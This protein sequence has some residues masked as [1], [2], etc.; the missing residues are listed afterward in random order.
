MTSIDKILIR[1]FQGA[2]S[3][4]T[5]V[6]T[7][8]SISPSE[9]SHMTAVPYVAAA[10]GANAGEATTVSPRPTTDH[11]MPDQPIT[12]QPITDQSTC[13]T[14]DRDCDSAVSH[15]NASDIAT[16]ESTASALVAYEGPETDL[17]I[18]DAE[19]V[20]RNAVD[21]PRELYVEPTQSTQQ[22][23]VATLRDEQPAVESA[24]STESTINDGG[25]VPSTGTACTIIIDAY[26]PNV[27]PAERVDPIDCLD[28]IPATELSGVVEAMDRPQSAYQLWL[29][30]R[31]A[32]A[33]PEPESLKVT[34]HP[35]EL[36][37]AGESTDTVTRDDGVPTQPVE[38]NSEL[39]HPPAAPNLIND[40]PSRRDFSPAWEVDGLSWSTVVA[41][42][43]DATEQQIGEFVNWV[44][45][46]KP[47]HETPCLSVTS[48]QRGEGRTTLACLIA[49]QA[50]SRG[51]RVALVDN[52]HQSPQ[53]AA[54]MGLLP[55][56][57]WNELTAGEA[58]DQAAIHSL[59]DQL[60]LF[61]LR[62]DSQQDADLSRVVAELR[63]HFDLIVIDGPPIDALR[64]TSFATHEA[65]VYLIVRNAE[66]TS[67]LDL[68]RGQIQLQG[69]G[70]GCLGIAKNFAA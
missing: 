3:I 70:V 35:N 66:V 2:Q 15:A 45:E 5:S 65:N 32:N 64:E 42:I 47:P 17:P 19:D 24:P 43:A 41:E 54:Q 49:K 67:E 16:S 44:Q 52:D 13:K 38:I 9:V 51:L 30:D 14:D 55:E 31:S 8:D 21:Q 10:D 11:S 1:A 61:P 7:T 53:L 60:T 39:E 12:D 6:I 28:G 29:N 48:C 40:E 36:S 56:L 58:L 62:A 25:E 34:S 4:A 33:D 63:Q 50:A 20:R 18:R 22:P 23:A 69:M 68:R 46:D 57:G 37:E 26:E 27:G 59:H